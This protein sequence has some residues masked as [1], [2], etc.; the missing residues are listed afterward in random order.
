TGAT[1]NINGTPIDAMLDGGY[2]TITPDAQPT[3]GS[4]D[5][6]LY[7]RGYT[8]LGGAT[9]QQLGV[10]KRSNASSPWKG[11]GPSGGSTGQE[12]FHSNATQNISGGTVVAKRTGVQTFSDF[13]IGMG[14]AVLPV[15]LVS[16]TGH[17]EGAT[18]ELE[19]VT[20]SEQ[21][22]K[23]FVLERSTDATTFEALYTTSAAGNSTVT[24]TYRYTDHQPFAG[25]NYYRLKAVD[26]DETF[27]YS[28]VIA[29]TRPWIGNDGFVFPN[30]AS[31]ILHLQTNAAA[32]HVTRV[33][34]VD[35]LGRVLMTD[36]VPMAKG[37]NTA[38]FSTQRLA[39]G[40][41]IL[42]VTGETN[43][44]AREYKFVKN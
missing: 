30:P 19:W 15:E 34:I 7:E 10:I 4:Y 22:S 36:E 33:E 35:L 18:N 32:A 12:G 9:A 24:L 5:V 29:I 40:V 25:V 13:G 38:L 28:N 43:A 1:T 27:S 41:Y 16:F 17:N 23:A 26:L 42:R 21:N 8:N 39:Q 11:T 2:W 6:T 44:P 31:D 20:A 14:N 37:L 3:A